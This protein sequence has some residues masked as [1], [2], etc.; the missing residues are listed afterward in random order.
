MSQI[1]LKD[2]PIT[3]RHIDSPVG[4][5]LLAS[6]DD[7]LRLIEF[8]AP[9]HPAAIDARWQPGDNAV[10][11]ET[12]KQ[13]DEYF[14]GTRRAFDLPLAPHGT[15]FQLQCWRT[16]ALI[17]W[18]Q[19]WSY[20]QMARHL[21]QASAM[22]AVGAANGRNPLPI[23]LPCHRVIGA[24]GSLTG[25]GGGLPTKRFLLELEGAL[26]PANDLFG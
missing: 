11:S 20:G 17:P 25:F 23:V 12:Q 4:P 15:A 24:D 13:L 10:L 26:A 14:A 2:G 21:G 5:L 9:W 18:G 8:E 6:G 22:R 3:Y 19:T 7:G 16:L 1:R